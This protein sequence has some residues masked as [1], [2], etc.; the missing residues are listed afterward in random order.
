MTDD[1]AIRAVEDVVAVERMA[2]GMVRVVTWSDEY[3][4]DARDGGC[5]CP[6][7]EYNLQ[8]EGR[9]KHEWAAVLATTELPSPTEPVESLT[10]DAPTP[11]LADG[12]ERPDDCL[13]SGSTIEK[14][15]CHACLEAGYDNPNPNPPRENPYHD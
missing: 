13:C 3:T 9:C 2:P 8:G 14:L 7:Q 1:R 6:D 5:T 11:I 15:P 12:G 4:V 10:A